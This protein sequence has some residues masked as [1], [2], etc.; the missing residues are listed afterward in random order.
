L[1][2]SARNLGKVQDGQR[3]I[4][5]ALR[6]LDSMTERERYSTR[7]FYYRITG[8]YQQCVK[9]YGELI[10]RYA[11]DIVGHNGLA[12]CA[13]QLRDMSRARDEVRKVVDMLPNRALFR[14]NLALYSNYAGD[15]QTG[16]TEARKVGDTDT[17][18]NLAIAFSQLGREQLP[19][20]RE[21]YERL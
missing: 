9:E 8:D 11:A 2:V 18:A 16:E 15:F 7:G 5:Q 17:Y 20:A 21:T 14:D 6:Y 4:N 12:L 19:Q 3:Y 1:A 10:V 13:S